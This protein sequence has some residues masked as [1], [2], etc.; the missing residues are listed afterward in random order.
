L[1]GG[2]GREGGVDTAVVVGDPACEHADIVTTIS[3]PNLPRY[4]AIA[5]PP[6]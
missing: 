5:R 1:G 4:V 3:V 2:G 6:G